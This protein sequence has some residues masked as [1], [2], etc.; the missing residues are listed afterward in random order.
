MII[1]HSVLFLIIDIDNTDTT[2]FSTQS[3]NFEGKYYR[4]IIIHSCSMHVHV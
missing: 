4:Y 1:T 2:V 3:L